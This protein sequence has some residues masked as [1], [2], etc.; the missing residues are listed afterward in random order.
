[1]RRFSREHPFD[2]PDSVPETL[3]VR[4]VPPSVNQD[5][6]NEHFSQAY[7]IVP[8]DLKIT[9]DCSKVI[10]SQERII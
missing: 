7:G 10:R 8:S 4:N 9:Q 6:L 1:M 3:M 2:V 5:A